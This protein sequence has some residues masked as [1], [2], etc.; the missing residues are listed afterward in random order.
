MLSIPFP[1]VMTLKSQLKAKSMPPANASGIFQHDH[2]YPCPGH[3]VPI[4]RCHR[5]EGKGQQS[6]DEGIEEICMVSATHL[7]PVCRGLDS[8]PP[9]LPALTFEEVLDLHCPSKV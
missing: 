4:D 9:H 5:D 6:D 2:R 8:H 1:D 7:G 3:T